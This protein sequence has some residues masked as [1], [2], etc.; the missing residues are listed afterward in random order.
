VD[1]IIDTY[2]F[3]HVRTFKLSLFALLLI[4][5]GLY[6]DVDDFVKHLDASLA[7]HIDPSAHAAV[8]SEFWSSSDITVTASHTPNNT[9]V[10]EAAHT[11]TL[12]DK[13]N[14]AAFYSMAM[15]KHAIKFNAYGIYSAY[16][17]PGQVRRWVRLLILLVSFVSMT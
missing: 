12:L 6:S 15:G 9:N 7:Q 3:L 10:A 13:V 17:G 14:R 5:I 2:Y 8:W 16:A 4:S 11:V 1:P